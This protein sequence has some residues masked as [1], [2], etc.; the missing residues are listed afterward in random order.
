MNNAL[1]ELINKNGGTISIAQFM[2]FALYDKQYGYYINKNPIGQDFITAPEI[3]QLFAETIAIWIILQ[4]KD[5]GKPQQFIIAELGPG[6][7]TMI[8]DILRTTH[9]YFSKYVEIYLFEVSPKLEQVQKKK[10]HNYNNIFWL[11][12]IED[13]PDRPTIL[14]ANEFFDA[15]PIR[16]FIYKNIWYERC[17]GMSNNSF[18]FTLKK[19]NTYFETK[20]ENAIIEVNEPA[21][22]IFKKIKSQLNKNGGKALIIDYGYTKKPYISTLQGITNHKHSNILENI[23]N[24]DI[25]AHIDF[26]IFQNCQ[27]MTQRNFLYSHGVKERAGILLKQANQKQAGDILLALHK[28]TATETMGELFK[29]VII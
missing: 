20:R 17:I 3:S 5:L 25:T 13:L 26:S 27:I 12:N 8:S 19:T 14:V 24:A 2:N 18:S 10:L 4:W 7:G 9:K 11:K 15:L 23:G 22:I 16:Q 29:C 1:T 21:S 6:K 28:L